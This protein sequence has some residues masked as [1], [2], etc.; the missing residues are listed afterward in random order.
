MLNVLR[1]SVNGNIGN[2]PMPRTLDAAE[3]A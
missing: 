1:V 2:S 3:L